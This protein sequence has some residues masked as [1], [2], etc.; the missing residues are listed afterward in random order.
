MHRCRILI[1]DDSPEDYYAYRRFILAAFPQSVCEWATT[2][3]AGQ[4]ALQAGEFNCVLLDHGLPGTTGLELLRALAPENRDRL[5][6]VMIT[7][8]G[9]QSIAVEAMKHGASDYLDKSGISGE[10]LCRAVR[11]ALEQ[12]ELRQH[13]AEQ[14]L[15]LKQQAARLQSIVAAVESATDAVVIFDPEGVVTYLN[16]AAKDLAGPQAEHMVGTRADLSPSARNAEIRAAIAAGRAWQGTAAAHMDD[17]RTLELEMSVSPI[18]DADGTVASYVAVARDVSER[19]L[20]TR[21]LAQAQKLESIGQLAAGIAHEINTPIQYVADN[22]RFLAEVFGELTGLIDAL[23]GLR[24]ANLPDSGA[25]PF[26]QALERCDLDYL[27]AEI[28]RAIEQSV[29]GIERI[30]NIVHA[31]K[32]FSHPGQ[33]KVL[34]DLNSTIERSVAVATHEWKLIANV[35]MALDP[36]LPMVR[37]VPSAISHAIVNMVVNAAHAIAEKLGE[38]PHEKGTIT[39]ATRRA[40]QAAEITI[41]DDGP[42]IADAARERIF[43]PFFT[44][45]AVGKGTGQ[46]LAIVYDVVV[47]QHG[48]RIDVDSEPGK[49]TR[50]A[51]HIPLDPET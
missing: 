50:F 36:E 15:A 18:S 45:K 31:M 25:A 32:D 23:A 44:T 22:T 26:R 24:A 21:Q 48:G 12:L 41:A 34:T 14:Q 35:C 13:I 46:G 10:S 6:I 51:I 47:K 9:D 16:P 39:L 27:R 28:P 33:D 29:E 30:T 37:C 19:T 11:G 5:A 4:T 38:S 43:D 17:G 2:A 49:G 7:G 20:L 8:R 40:G 1:V 3:A 42:G